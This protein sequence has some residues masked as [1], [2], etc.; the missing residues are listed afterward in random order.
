SFPATATVTAFVLA[1]LT[2]P[3]APEEPGGSA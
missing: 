2:A 3:P 1:G